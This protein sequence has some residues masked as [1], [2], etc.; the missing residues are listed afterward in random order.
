MVGRFADSRGGEKNLG[1]DDILVNILQPPLPPKEQRTKETKKSFK[2]YLR[3][4]F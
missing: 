2:L 1:F 3:N 4:N